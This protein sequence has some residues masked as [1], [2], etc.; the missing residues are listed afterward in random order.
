MEVIF[1]E[2]YIQSFSDKESLSRAIDTLLGNKTNTNNIK[3]I[4][5]NNDI[6]TLNTQ[7]I[8]VEKAEPASFGDKVSAFFTGE[9]PTTGTLDNIDLSREKQERYENELNQG[10]YLLINKN[11]FADDNRHESNDVG[12]TAHDSRINNGERHDFDRVD[13]QDHRLTD[14]TINTR[15][16]YDNGFG[17]EEVRHNNT[18]LDRD[19]HVDHSNEESVTLHEEE[20]NVDKDRVQTGEVHLDKNVE[21]R[22]EQFDVPV[23]REEVIVERRSVDPDRDAG[24]TS[25]DEDEVTIPVHEERVNVEKETV[26]NEEIVIRKEKHQDTVHVDEELRRED[27]DVDDEQNHNHRR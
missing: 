14:D 5:P 17:R 10:H 22:R 8:Q 23:E 6:D 26:A 27:V 24:H 13:E 1:M 15:N 18:D 12:V 4:T 2:R 3:V 20:L 21:T 11:G 19:R 9:T 16:E 7:G 25:F